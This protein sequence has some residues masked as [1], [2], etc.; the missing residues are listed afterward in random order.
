M[1]ID[2]MM[3]GDKDTGSAV[4]A[5]AFGLTVGLGE[6]GKVALGYETMEDATATGTKTVMATGQAGGITIDNSDKGGGKL[7]ASKVVWRDAMKNVYDPGDNE[8]VITYKYDSNGATAEGDMHDVMA[9][10]IHHANDVTSIDDSSTTRDMA[11]SSPNEKIH[12]I[13][14]KFYYQ[15][16]VPTAN[17]ADVCVWN[18]DGTK[19]L[20]QHCDGKKETNQTEDDD[21]DSTTVWVSSK[22][23]VDGDHGKKDD[24]GVKVYTVRSASGSTVTPS[25]TV[26]ETFK[27]DPDY[28]GK[29][30][31]I[32]AEFDIG[33]VILGLGHSS[34]DSNDPMKTKKAKTNYLGVRGAVGD[35]N[36]SWYVW[37]R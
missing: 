16:S 21:I 2:A 32:S 34:E 11:D 36:L 14:G 7:D 24:K 33:G 22:Y 23:V 5:A 27:A 19:K 28:G 3:D 18:D 13:N 31:H 29:K 20:G 30:S 4:D 6:Y 8:A 17:G 9:M 37:G 10:V 35:T 25:A 1:Q 15:V 12:L 26:K